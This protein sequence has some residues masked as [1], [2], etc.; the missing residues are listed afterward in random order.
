MQ[1]A[2]EQESPDSKNQEQ[3]VSLLF[4]ALAFLKVGLTAWGG[5]MALVSIVQGLLV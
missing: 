5:F 4:L 3:R 1:R 2:S